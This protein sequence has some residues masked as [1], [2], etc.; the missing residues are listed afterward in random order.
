MKKKV[1]YVVIGIIIIVGIIV[2]ALKGLNLGLEYQANEKLELYIGKVVDRKD[3]EEIA[4][5]VFGKGENKV[6]IIEIFNDMVSIT[7]RESNDEQIEKFINTVNEK[8]GVEYTKDDVEIVKEPQM[9]IMD[10]ISP[11]IIPVVIAAILAVLYIAIRYY[12]LGFW[13]TLLFSILTVVVIEALLYSVY[14]ITRLP[15]NSM[16]IPIALSVFVLTV[17][18]ITINC[19]NKLKKIKKDVEE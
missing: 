2:G 1:L 19:E 3:I 14:A 11:Y 10:I 17:L 12:K 5:D 16:T 15:V 18:G 8:Y 7:V 9:N 13:K 4:N 6:Q